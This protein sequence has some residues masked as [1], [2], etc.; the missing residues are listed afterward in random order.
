[1]DL[2]SLAGRRFSDIYDGLAVEFSGADPERIREITVLKF[3]LEKAQAAGSL[4][5]EDLV[6]MSHLIER[7][8]KALRLAQQRQHAAAAS[9]PSL[10]DHLAKAAKAGGP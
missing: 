3:E 9:A 5:L 10:R 1:M 2:R 4:S 8:E 7:R 6:R